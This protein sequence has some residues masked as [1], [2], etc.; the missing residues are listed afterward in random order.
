MK[1]AKLFFLISAVLVITLLSV[2]GA[3]AGPAGQT[4]NAGASATGG[5]GKA[6]G[7]DEFDKLAADNPTQQGQTLTGAVRQLSG[8]TVCFTVPW[9]QSPGA[10]TIAKLDNGSWVSGGITTAN[11]GQAADGSGLEYCADVGAGTFGFIQ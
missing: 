2:G 9:G 1:K 6:I 11:N 4:S 7:G 3:W 8:G 10:L 5:A